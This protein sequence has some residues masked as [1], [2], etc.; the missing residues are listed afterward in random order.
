MIINEYNDNA[1]NL[2]TGDL[3]IVASPKYH[4]SF[5]EK[6][7]GAPTLLWCQWENASFKSKA[8][9][10]KYYSLLMFSDG[11]LNPLMPGGNN[12]VAHT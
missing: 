1:R 11:V 7:Q 3:W 6:I 4:L 10:S 12:T 2:W 8:A 9:V 5:S